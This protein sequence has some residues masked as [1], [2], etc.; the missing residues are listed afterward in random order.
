MKYCEKCRVDVRGQDELCPLC[1]CPL[2]GSGEAEVFPVIAPE[3]KKFLL[4]FKILTLACVA[5]AIL[6]IALNL[7]ITDRYT[8]SIK[9]V[10]GI[11]CFW[12]MLHLAINKRHKIIK[13]IGF[14]A[15]LAA[16]L[17]VVWDFVTGYRGWSVDF[18]IPLVCIAAIIA[19]GVIGMTLKLPYGDYIFYELAAGVLGLI[20]YIL[21]L[22][23]KVTVIYPSLICS[24]LSL[25]LLAYLL[26]FCRKTI[27]VEVNKRFHV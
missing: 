24:A 2:K 13:N 25:V 21:Y 3:K 5:C 1:Q 18:V 7:M 8:W 22:L 20:P 12:L 26:L 14:E 17:S 15:V 11:F 19:F 10:F 16:V 6:S 27:W 9:A 23:N 4:F